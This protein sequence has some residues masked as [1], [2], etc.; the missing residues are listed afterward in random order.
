MRTLLIVGSSTT[1][2]VTR[3]ATTVVFTP[4]HY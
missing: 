1:R 4:R 2:V 3:G